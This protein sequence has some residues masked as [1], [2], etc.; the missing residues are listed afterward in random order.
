MGMQITP[1]RPAL[2]RMPDVAE[3]LRQMA[4][5]AS[6][7]AASLAAEEIA[8]LRAAAG[9][10][11][12]ALEPALPT[13]NP[14][15]GVR[16]RLQALLDA[17]DALDADYQRLSDYRT[18]PMMRERSLVYEA[19]AVHRDIDDA[20]QDADRAAR[21][22]HYEAAIRQSL[23]PVLDAIVQGEKLEDLVSGMGRPD[24]ADVA[25][26]V[27]LAAEGRARIAIETWRRPHTMT[28]LR[29]VL[30]ARGRLYLL[31]D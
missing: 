12:D 1:C 23:G 20:L 15:P 17:R 4:I 6:E 29:H 10:L 19:G 16:P 5:P 24:Y 9:R 3:E 11:A 28:A 13:L 18:R 31:D 26:R 2:E 22:R 25:A 30:D 8:A 7:D 21:D 14:A 27:T